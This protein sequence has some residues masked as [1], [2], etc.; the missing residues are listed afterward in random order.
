MAFMRD[1]IGRC[2]TSIKN[3]PGVSKRAPRCRS[4]ILLALFNPACNATQ[5]RGSGCVHCARSDQRGRALFE[6]DGPVQ[7]ATWLID[8]SRREL[9]ETMIIATADPN[10]PLWLVFILLMLLGCIVFWIPTVIAFHRKHIDRW[11]IL[12]LNLVLAGTG[13]GW[14]A[15]LIWSLGKIGRK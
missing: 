10:D 8:Q 13:I 6:A 3:D 1:R 15:A 4:L 2:R 11:W 7:E 5:P 12:L 14:F 9:I